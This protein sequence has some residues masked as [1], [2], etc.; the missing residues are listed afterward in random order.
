M[1]LLSGR[2]P[3]PTMIQIKLVQWVLCGWNIGC[4]KWNSFHI[5]LFKSIYSFGEQRGHWYHSS[6]LF[7]FQNGSKETSKR[8]TYCWM[9]FQ[10]QITQ[11]KYCSVRSQRN[12]MN[13]VSVVGEVDTMHCMSFECAMMTFSIFKS[14]SL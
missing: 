5:I 2:I 11:T 14:C 1:L 4:I 3:S 12:L 7:C 13:K 8:K 9:K 6:T 10:S